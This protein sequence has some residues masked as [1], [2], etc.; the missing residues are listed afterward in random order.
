[1]CQEALSAAALDG[2]PM[3]D[4]PG[5]A[6]YTDEVWRLGDESL[7]PGLAYVVFPGNVGEADTMTRMVMSLSQKSR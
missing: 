5:A 7:T 6:A 3:S 4:V 2:D 1:M